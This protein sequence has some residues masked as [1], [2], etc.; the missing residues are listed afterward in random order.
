[1]ISFKKTSRIG[2]NKPLIR[3]R[4][5]KHI[6]YK[7]GLNVPHNTPKA[8]L[9]HIVLGH[10]SDHISDK[11][12]IF[13]GRMIDSSAENPVSFNDLAKTNGI[14]QNSAVTVYYNIIAKISESITNA[15]AKS[16]ESSAVPVSEADLQEFSLRQWQITNDERVPLE[17]LS[18]KIK[19]ALNSLP[20]KHRMIIEIR[21]GLLNGKARSLEETGQEMNYTR[22]RIRQIEKEALAMMKELIKEPSQTRRSLKPV[23]HKPTAK[24]LLEQIPITEPNKDCLKKII[25][26]LIAVFAR[27]QMGPKADIE[28]VLAHD[29]FEVWF[30][31]INENKLRIAFYKAFSKLGWHEAEMF[32]LR[33]GIYDDCKVPMKETSNF[34]RIPMADCQEHLDQAYKILIQDQKLSDFLMGYLKSI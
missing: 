34:L 23:E 32:G 30:S 22:E 3:D 24:E 31:W 9:L 20:A 26:A 21:Y 25:K 27:S 28:R 19:A 14:K 33:F 7:A 10:I 17:G 15:K 29:F 13:I 8:R 4:V 11:N 6:A 18:I 1:M 12:L 5:L 2:L 16:I